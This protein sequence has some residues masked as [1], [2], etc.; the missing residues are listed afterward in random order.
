M[1]HEWTEGMILMYR[2]KTFFLVRPSLA[3]S[4]AYIIIG[5]GKKTL[6]NLDCRNDYLAKR[7]KYPTITKAFR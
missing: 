6:T 7:K 5:L 3:I 1:H 2:M 4:R